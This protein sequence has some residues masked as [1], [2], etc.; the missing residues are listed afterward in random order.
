MVSLKLW[1][2]LLKPCSVF[3]CLVGDIHRFIESTNTPKV[4]SDRNDRDPSKD[5]YFGLPHSFVF[6]MAHVFECDLGL[7]IFTNNSAIESKALASL[8]CLAN[9][10]IN[11]GCTARKILWWRFNGSHNSSDTNSI[12]AQGTNRCALSS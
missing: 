4:N 9:L 7:V 3:F 12:P 5:I 1:T 8:V 6:I 10:R 11:L 2:A